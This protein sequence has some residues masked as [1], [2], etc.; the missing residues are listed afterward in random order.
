[1][2]FFVFVQFIYGKTEVSEEFNWF[3]QIGL[4][5]TD[6]FVL[7]SKDIPADVS[8]W[9][10]VKNHVLPAGPTGLHYMLK[11]N[12]L[13]IV[14]GYPALSGLEGTGAWNHNG[15]RLIAVSRTPVLSEART[16][17]YVILQTFDPDSVWATWLAEE[18]AQRIFGILGGFDPAREPLLFPEVEERREA[19]RLAKVREEKAVREMIAAREAKKQQEGG[20]KDRSASESKADN[21]PNLFFWVLGLCSILLL[22]SLLRI[23]GRKNKR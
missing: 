8:E 11:T 4:D 23:V 7:R 12:R 14:P 17:R 19:E 5:L 1:M 22:A 20:S 15:S 2:V 3:R 16:G 13:A 6:S 9:P 18:D 10:L 21:Q